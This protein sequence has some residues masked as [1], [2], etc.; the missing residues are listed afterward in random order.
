MRRHAILSALV[1]LIGGCTAE[2]DKKSVRATQTAPEST[3]VEVVRISYEP[4]LPRYVVTVEPLSFDASGD[5]NGSAPPVPGRRYGWGPFGW[6]LLP[7]GPQARP[8]NP[9][10]Q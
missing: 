7:E 4:S 8:Y 2:V 10:P 3:Q 9:P 6:G 5:G 1:L